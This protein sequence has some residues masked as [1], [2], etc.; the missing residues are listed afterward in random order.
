MKLFVVIL[1]SIP[2]IICNSYCVH[3]S[4][5][6]LSTKSSFKASRSPLQAT[7]TS[8]NT[9]IAIQKTVSSL[10][11]LIGA[12]STTPSFA[13]DSTPQFDPALEVRVVPPP[14]KSRRPFAWSVEM[15]DPQYLQ[16]R[17][18]KGEKS[19][20]TRLVNSKVVLFG[21]H[22]G[23]DQDHQLEINL[24]ERMIN[25]NPNR[26]IVLAS[27]AFPQIDT[28]DEALAE[29]STSKPPKEFKAAESVQV[30]CFSVVVAM[31]SQLH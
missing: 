15:A 30:I 24:L 23:S 28:I 17:T 8:I 5:S 4:I 29:F 10:L 12:F 2:L 25:I 26:K 1:L 13:V 16:P 21:D 27:Q 18:E 19:L 14:P 11:V 7:S 6:A 9:R 22:R 31:I 3:P 20:L